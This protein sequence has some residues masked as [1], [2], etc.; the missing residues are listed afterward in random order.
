MDMYMYT[1]VHSCMWIWSCVS[2]HLCKGQKTTMGTGP[3]WCLAWN[4]LPL[5][6]FHCLHSL[7]RQ[8]T[9]VSISHHP[10]GVLEL[11]MF[12]LH[13]G[14]LHGLWGVCIPVLMYAHQILLTTVCLQMCRV[15]S[16]LWLYWCLR[17][18]THVESDSGLHMTRKDISLCPLQGRWAWRN[19]WDWSQHSPLSTQHK[20]LAFPSEGEK[21]LHTKGH[22]LR[23]SWRFRWRHGN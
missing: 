3:Q 5:L 11:Q 1:H 7:T 13:I 23:A 15:V 14:L 8:G 4:R 17:L 9:P 2:T 18:G 21:W 22:W 6:F 20:V 16:L 19:S 10:A 12:T